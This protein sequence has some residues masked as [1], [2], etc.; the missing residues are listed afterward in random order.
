[1]ALLLTSWTAKTFARF[2]P[3]N[4]NPIVL[5]G[6]V[7]RNVVIGIVLLAALASVLSGMLPAWRSS[8][9]PAIE[10]LKDEAASIS[11]GTHN[12]RLLSGLVVGRSR[13]R[14]RCW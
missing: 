10:A 1:V 3:A 8:H 4:S 12:R 6:S 7:D 14:W 13:F 2:I 5:N 11:G 9:V